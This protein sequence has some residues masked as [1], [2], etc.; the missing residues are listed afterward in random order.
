MPLILGDDSAEFIQWWIKMKKDKNYETFSIGSAPGIGA[1]A[2]WVSLAILDKVKV[3]KEMMLPE[4]PVLQN[5]VEQYASL[6]PGM[7]VSPDFTWEYVQKH[8]LN[9]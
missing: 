2:F 5:E 1:A 3:P 6:Q 4:S 9:Q 7:V 8:L